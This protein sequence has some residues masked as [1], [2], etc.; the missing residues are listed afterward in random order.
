[1]YPDPV[2]EPR[3]PGGFLRP[4]HRAREYVLEP[5]AGKQSAE[6]HRLQLAFADERDIGAPGVLSRDG[7]SRLAVPSEPERHGHE[8]YASSG[9]G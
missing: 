4:A 6:C 2:A 9:I 7:P 8:A 1:V 5:A 3:Q